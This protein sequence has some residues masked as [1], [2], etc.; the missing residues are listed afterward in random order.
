MKGYEVVIVGG[1]IVGCSIAYH[2]AVKG[3]HRVLLLERNQIGSGST[4]RSAAGVRQQ[5]S[6][7]LGIR[8]MMESVQMFKRFRDEVGVDP[9]F[10]QV[11]YV[12]LA[13]T[14][15]HLE[16]FR[17]NVALQRS[18]GLDVRLVSPSDIRELLPQLSLDDVVGG[19]YCP[20]D[21]FVG[22]N[23]VCWG[24]ARAA[25]N[26]GVEIRENSPVTGVRVD[27]SR[28]EVTSGAEG[29]TAD[30][31][32]IAAGAWSGEIGK[33]IGLEIPIEPSKRYIFM[34]SP[35]DGLPDDMPMVM[36]VGQGIYMRKETGCVLIGLGD[37]GDTDGFDMQ[38]D[39]SKAGVAAEKAVHRVPGLMSASLARGWAGLFEQTPDHNP[40]IGRVPGMERVYI[41]SGFSGHG[42]MHSPIAGRL[43]AEDVVEG[44]PS[45]DISPLSY[46]RFSEGKLL[47]ETMVSI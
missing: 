26:L 39:W 34:T 31:L 4:A 11:G 41:C 28:I 20:S 6:T 40:I 46:R 44:K 18:L 15:E 24:Y 30:L 38:L 9:Q 16:G 17:R 47:H 19:T 3:L 27:A 22:P 1:G 32:I 37:M 36:D 43:V 33:L 29:F 10:R 7:A 42:V 25:R 45:L 2:L 12:F 14:S 35:Y 13:P 5:F 8:M 23:E 21:G